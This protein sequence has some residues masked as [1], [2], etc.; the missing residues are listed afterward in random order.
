MIAKTTSP[1]EEV[2]F[3]QLSSM[4]ISE[5]HPQ[6]GI[7]HL[8]DQPFSILFSL[9]ASFNFLAIILRVDAFNLQFL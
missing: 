7:R 6:P 4:S 8:A 5:W 1:P 3:S 9:I 2:K